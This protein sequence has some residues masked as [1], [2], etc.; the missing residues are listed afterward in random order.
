MTMEVGG[1]DGVD[2]NDLWKWGGTLV[3]MVLLSWFMIKK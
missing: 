1:Q 3:L 2:E